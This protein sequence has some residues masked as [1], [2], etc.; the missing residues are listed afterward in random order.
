MSAISAGPSYPQCSLCFSQAGGGILM[1]SPVFA[2]ATVSI[3]YL[4]WRVLL[5][6]V[7]ID[8]EAIAP[9]RRARVY[10]LR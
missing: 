4:N 7:S 9:L 5:H 3:V 8:I 2:S 1:P 6:Y 10:L